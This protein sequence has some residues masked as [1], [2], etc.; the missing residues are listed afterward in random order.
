MYSAWGAAILPSN[1]E[2]EKPS[3]SART[4]PYQRDPYK[5][6]PRETVKQNTLESMSEEPHLALQQE[7]CIL[8][9]EKYKEFFKQKIVKIKLCCA[10]SELY[11]TAI[12]HINELQQTG[13]LTES[14]KNVLL[15]IIQKNANEKGGILRKT[16]PNLN[17]NLL[18]EYN[19]TCVWVCKLIQ[20]KIFSIETTDKLKCYLASFLIGMAFVN[21]HLSNEAQKIKYA[22]TALDVINTITQEIVINPYGRDKVDFEKT[23]M[24]ALC[25]SIIDGTYLPRECKAR[26][27]RSAQR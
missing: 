26:K 12:Q 23:K 2:A 1:E 7:V 8:T 15:K 19:G 10:S 13:Q 25:Q 24:Q 17:E 6:V 4:T 5:A 22:I 14:D 9:P 11:P 27:E 18:K 21:R 16:T 3:R 20:T